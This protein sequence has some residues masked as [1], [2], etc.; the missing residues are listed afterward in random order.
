VIDPK[1]LRDIAIA[2]GKTGFAKETAG[3]PLGLFQEVVRT[4]HHLETRTFRIKHARGELTAPLMAQPA[5][6]EKSWWTETMRSYAAVVVLDDVLTR[7]QIEEVRG[8]SPEDWWVAVKTAASAIE[9]HGGKPVVL[10]ANLAA[11]VWL[12]HWLR[13]I[14]IPTRAAR[15]ADLRVWQSKD[16]LGPGYQLHLN[17][18][19]V[20]QGPIGDTCSYVLPGELLRRAEFTDYGDGQPVL[21]EFKDDPADPWHGVLKASIA[22]RVTLGDGIVA[23]VRFADDAPEEDDVAA[24]G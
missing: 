19:P 4:P 23:R 16:K 8:E 6:N 11:P 9:R 12:S 1:R 15:P 14:P 24:S 10:I 22:C 18:I 2:G 21:V 7:A 20:F 5:S 17:E 13:N 3:C